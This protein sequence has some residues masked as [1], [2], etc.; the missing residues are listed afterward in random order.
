MGRNVA[1]AF[2]LGECQR[3]DWNRSPRG[4][5]P[6]S[7]LVPHQGSWGRT[8]VKVRCLWHIEPVHIWK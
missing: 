7:H 4:L 5:D 3:W 6:Q 8:V 1:Q 2:L